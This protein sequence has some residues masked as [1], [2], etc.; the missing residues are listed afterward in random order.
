MTEEDKK[1]NRYKRIYNQ[2]EELM[3]KSKEPNARMCSIVAVLHHKM[4]KFFWTGFYL[5]TT[6][7]RLVVSTYQ[8]ALAC[9]E[10]KQ[11]TGVC[12]TAINKKENLIVNNVEDFPGHI[13][14]DCRSKSE[15][16]IP[17][18][19]ENKIIGVLD[20]DSDQLGA[21]DEIDAEFLEKIV[22]LVYN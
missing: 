21:F 2:L 17:L 13:A 11:N 4:P 12:W 3:L 10:L 16:V 18:K 20:V 15:I 1:I 6:D 14:C 8:G 5:L 22:K 7:K 9:M 19:Q